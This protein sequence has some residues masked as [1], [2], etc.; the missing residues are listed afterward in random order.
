LTSDEACRRMYLEYLDMH[1][2][3]L[4]Q[5]ALDVQTPAA[6]SSSSPRRR[7]VPLPQAMRYVFV[8]TASLAASLLVQVVWLHP[9]DRTP[10]PSAAPVAAEPLPK[11]VAT[12]TDAA[13]CVWIQAADA[14]RA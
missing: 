2:R 3:L 1:A 11:Y 7:P 5:P 9:Q 12:L 6:A 13:G 14:W 4:V 10:A 8:A